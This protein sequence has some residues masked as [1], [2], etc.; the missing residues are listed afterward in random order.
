MAVEGT[1]EERWPVVNVIGHMPGHASLPGESQMDNQLI[2]VLAQYDSP[3]PGPEALDYPAANDNAS[4]VAVML[5]A[6]RVLQETEYIPNR[7]FLFVAYSGEGLEGGEDVS[8]PEISRLLQAKRGFASA[9]VPEAIVHV[10]GV[11]GGSGDRL[12]VSAGGSLRLAELFESA[13]RKMGSGVKRG[14]Q[15]IDISV[16]YEEGS[17]FD[18]GQDVPEVRLSWEGWSENARLP[19]DT[20]DNISAD[21]LEDAG[22][23][24]ALALMIMGRE[25]QY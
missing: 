19:S 23:T 25:R 12:E 21:N 9:M 7:T 4:G 10:R 5:E 22:R 13:A 11:G 1:Q 3:P 2:L 6:I 24:L 8:N 20:L 14:E 18:S 17:P 15:A 16:I